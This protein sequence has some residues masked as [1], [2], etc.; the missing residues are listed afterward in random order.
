MIRIPKDESELRVRKQEG[1]D[2]ISIQYYY[3]NVIWEFLNKIRVMELLKPLNNIVRIEECY[4]RRENRPE[5]YIY[6]RM[7]LLE[8]LLSYIE[9]KPLSVEEI[10]KLGIDICEA[11]KICEAHNIIHGDIKPDNI[12]V[13]QFGTFKLG[14][15][16]IGKRMEN[17]QTKLY[18]KETSMYV[19]PEFYRDGV[20]GKTADI[21]AL[22]IILHNL[23]GSGRFR[24]PFM[25]SYSQ[26]A[27]LNLKDQA[28]YRQLNGK[29][30]ST[31]CGLGSTLEAVVAKACAPD[32]RIRY[33][34]AQE[35]QRDLIQWRDFSA[36]KIWEFPGNTLTKCISF[37]QMRI[38]EDSVS[39]NNPGQIMD[40]A[41]AQS[42][43]MIGN[44]YY[45]S[46]ET[47][48][49]TILRNSDGEYNAWLM[50]VT[51]ASFDDADT[52]FDD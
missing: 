6:I 36:N 49:V 30:A 29:S 45:T 10:V 7:E 26:L 25:P 5:W 17:S 15:F 1:M 52:G 39:G 35:F 13:D 19:A 47:V 34:T 40:S 43:D 48:G 20:V 42:R 41:L 12:F 22:G 27:T 11:L 23:M 28:L 24:F 4:I 33:Q 31:L 2:D 16:G 38:E 44:S 3:Q 14:D 51:L 21:Y 50:A 32:P 46:G 37:G 18:Q 9:R 8:G